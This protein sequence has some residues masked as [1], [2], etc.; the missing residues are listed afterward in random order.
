MKRKYSLDRLGVP[1]TLLQ[2]TLLVAAVRAQPA[3]QPMPKFESVLNRVGFDQR[4]GAQLP[5]E[6]RLFDE[7]GRERRLG[8][9][10]GQR[11]VILLFVYFRCPMLCGE[12][13]KG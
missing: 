8:E 1:L 10:F 4:L 13:L 11:P 7:T 3:S 12:E 9:Y 6:T 2:V 5:L